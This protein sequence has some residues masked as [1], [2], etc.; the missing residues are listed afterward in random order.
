MVEPVFLTVQLSGKLNEAVVLFALPDEEAIELWRAAIGSP[1]A[2]LQR[3]QP[4]VRG[5][6]AILTAS[7]SG[8]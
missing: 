5:H 4:F 8:G 2:L 1:E 7:E 3:G 6:F